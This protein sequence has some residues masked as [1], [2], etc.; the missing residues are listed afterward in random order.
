M[1]AFGAFVVETLDFEEQGWM[2]RCWQYMG[3]LGILIEIL[4]GPP[5]R[6]LGHSSLDNCSQTSLYY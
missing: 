4:H 2:V 1:E 3:K 5:F 6:P